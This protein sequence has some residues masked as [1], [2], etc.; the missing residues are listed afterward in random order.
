MAADAS[1]PYRFGDL[2]ALA[3]RS[4][5]QQVRSRVQEA[6]FA[7]YRQTDAWML[8]LLAHRP[9][10]IGQL[11]DAMGITRQAARQLA[12]GM[13]ERGYATFGTDPADA[14]RTL[15]VLTLGGESYARAV[16]Q[17]QDALNSALAD[18]VNA[19]DLAV[20]DAVLRAVFPGDQPRRRPD[21]S[22]PPPTPRWSSTTAPSLPSAWLQST[23]NPRTRTTG[24]MGTARH[25]A[26]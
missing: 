15:V 5:I 13:V 8:R 7:G 12:D 25:I 20:A 26:S 6:G 11:G 24:S 22:M 10:A 3:R 9:W 21:E 17:A 16:R 23:G 14:R 19:A 18:R 4:W 1:P 2:L